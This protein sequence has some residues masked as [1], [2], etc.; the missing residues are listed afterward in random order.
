[1][2]NSI[3]RKDSLIGREE[4]NVNEKACISVDACGYRLPSKY[5]NKTV[6]IYLT[7]QKLFVFDLY[8]G[9]EIVDYELSPIPGRIICKREHRRETEK[10][11][12]E[13]KAL[14]S[15]MFEGE[16]WK[17]FTKRNFKA[18]SRYVRDQCLEAKRYFMVKDIDIEILE[19]AL[20]YCLE[21]DTLSFSNLNDTYAYFKRESDGSKDVLQEIQTLDGEYQGP[22][23]PLDVSKRNISVYKAL[24]RRRERVVT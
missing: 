7:K 13:L 1:V 17:R 12:R 11:A 4:R 20:E 14:V 22:H 10:T 3:F 8:T 21:N 19:Q 15:D 6:E 24:I 23:E 16:S 18:F 2:R 9:K 5:R